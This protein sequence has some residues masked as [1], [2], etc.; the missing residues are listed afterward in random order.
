MPATL[1]HQPKEEF[2][3][4]LQNQIPKSVVKVFGTHKPAWGQMTSQH[5]IEHLAQVVI[6]STILS[7]KDRIMPNK[8]QEETAGFMLYSDAEFP[9]NIMN[10]MYKDGLPAYTHP[11]IEI[12]KSQLLKNLD[13]F[14][15]TFEKNPKGYSFN[16]FFGDM[17]YDQLL[18]LHTKHFKHH[19]KQFGQGF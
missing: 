8:Q 6:Y 13:T 1:S 9:Q 11:T 5:M 14:F 3:L 7:N 16:P 15:R 12:A 19:L 18:I 17:D 4:I 10:P 2:I